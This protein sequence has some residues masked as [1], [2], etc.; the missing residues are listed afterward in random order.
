MFAM[1]AEFIIL[2]KMYAKDAQIDKKMTLKI[3]AEG[4]HV[5]KM[6]PVFK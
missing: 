4:H 1:I 6:T 2:H 5:Y 3:K